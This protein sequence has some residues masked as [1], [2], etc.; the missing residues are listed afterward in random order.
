MNFPAVVFAFEQFTSSLYLI[1]VLFHSFR[2]RMDALPL[3]EYSYL[4]NFHYSH[5]TNKYEAATMRCTYVC[6]CDPTAIWMRRTL[7]IFEHRNKNERF[8]FY[9]LYLIH[10][11][12]VRPIDWTNCCYR[13]VPT[14]INYIKTGLVKNHNPQRWTARPQIAFPSR[15]W[16]ALDWST[17]IK[18]FFPFSFTLSFP[19][20]FC[21]SFNV[22]NGGLDTMFLR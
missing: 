12:N 22:S 6:M 17:N 14:A 9:T 21:S 19:F 7:V 3:H 2:P 20:C 18:V 5:S 15:T 13:T 1:I 8:D 4:I 10:V 16:F 11:Q